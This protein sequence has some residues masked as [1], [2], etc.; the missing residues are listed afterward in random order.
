MH[1]PSFVF[2]CWPGRLPGV[3]SFRCVRHPTTGNLHIFIVVKASVKWQLCIQ[4]ESKSKH[5]SFAGTTNK[6]DVLE[7]PLAQPNKA[8]QHSGPVKSDLSATLLA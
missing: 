5:K 2:S 7:P 1:H 3:K 8:I 6:V 4:E